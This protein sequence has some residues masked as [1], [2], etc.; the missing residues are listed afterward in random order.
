MAK[1]NDAYFRRREQ[2]KQAANAKRLSTEVARASLTGIRQV[3]TPEGISNGLTPPRLA[4]I[5]RSASMGSHHDQLTLSEEM[6]ERDAHYGAVLRT[7]KLALG[8]LEF[9]CEAF[10]D[11]DRDKELADFV[12]AQIRKPEFDEMVDE[13][14]DALGKGYSAV[15]LIWQTKQEPWVPLYAWRDP[16]WF[17][18]DQETG[19]ELRLYDEADPVNGLELEPN[20]WIVHRPRLK[21]GLPS[22]SGLARMAAIAYM[23]KSWTL[24]DWMAFADIY[25]LPLRVGKY[26][27]GATE[28]D[29]ATL[30]TAVSNIASDA[31]AVIPESMT[32]E[33]IEAARGSNSGGAGMFKELAD[34]LDAQI[35]KA[36]LGQTMTTDDGSS[37]SQAQVHNEVRLDILKSDAKQLAATLNRDLVR[38]LIDLNYGPQEN[39]PELVI[40]VPEPEDLQLL[41]NGLEKLVPLGLE[42]EQSVIRDK[43]NLPDPERNE[44][45]EP[46]GKLL[47]A[48]ARDGGSAESTTTANN[49]A[50]CPHCATA[51]NRQELD[52]IEAEAL[53]DWEPLMQPMIDPI[54]QLA[55]ECED[56][57]EFIARLPELLEQMDSSELVKSLA[58]ASFKARVDGEVD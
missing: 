28:D 9:G 56:E 26:G 31:G 20:K 3:W 34:Y 49:H 21:S 50:D 32:L 5:L 42:V 52:P 55:E 11:S 36:I 51:L 1:R 24:K 29:K 17:L 33:F 22:R 18:W 58:L 7:R 10:S 46:V 2:N 40:H 25:G 43:F 37:M 13:L 45:G 14:L 44:Q 12:R 23:C 53:A 15:E 6:E 8:G 16:R 54:Q 38:P 57:Q 48:T 39:Y 27:P 4:Q 30:V 35:S 19:R 41:I 47:Q